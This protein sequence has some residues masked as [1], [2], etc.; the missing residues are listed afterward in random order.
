[1]TKYFKYI[2]MF[3]CLLFI[4]NIDV[5]AKLYNAGDCIYNFSVEHNGA[6]GYLSMKISQGSS[7]NVTYYYAW[8]NLT[9]VN[10]SKW[11]IEGKDGLFHKDGIH[12]D[13]YDKNEKYDKCPSY[14]HYKVSDKTHIYFSD[15]ATETGYQLS[16]SNS[17]SGMKV[18][19]S[20]DGEGASCSQTN[21]DWLKELPEAKN[22]KKGESHC[23]Y[24]GDV[25]DGCYIL[26]LDFVA[27]ENEKEHKVYTN[28]QN[29]SKY[30]DPEIKADDSE[31]FRKTLLSGGV[32]PDAIS[33]K[34]NFT[35]GKFVYGLGNLGSPLTLVKEFSL[36]ADTTIIRSDKIKK[37]E[38]CSD[39]ITDD[40]A[41]MLKSIIS[42]IRIIVPIIL[43][44]FGVADFGTAVF[45]GD[46]DKMKK[47]QNKFIKRLIIGVIIF[48]IPNILKLLL[49][50]AH[51]I[52]PVVD[53]TLCNII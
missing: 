50:I 35:K 6:K 28:F 16:T 21:V 12:I 44:G 36:N 53:A 48:I 30:P 26:Q 46:E 22:L 2:C 43:I 41:K 39:L 7:G 5:K 14:G 15:N 47:S 29:W 42:Y 18:S 25:D 38:K 32:C 49:S 3:I 33:V 51:S 8:E 45:A 34:G 24:Y 9:D 23:L 37:I 1:M 17:H 4:F 11:E 27:T 19:T 10:D 40:L 31:K 13:N 20:T 52:W